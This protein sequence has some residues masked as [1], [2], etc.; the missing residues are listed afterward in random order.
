MEGSERVLTPQELKQ[1][2]IQLFRD[3]AAWRKPERIPF[4]A[5]IVTWKIINA[6]Y[7]FSEALH[8]YDIMQ[9]CVTKF[10]DTYRVDVLTDTGVRNPMRIP[11]AIGES[12]YYVD[13]EQEVLGVHAYSLCDSK[14]LLE[15]SENTDKFIWEK[16]LPRKFPGF[17]ELKLED[18]QRALDEQIA[19]NNYTFK[20]TQIVREKYGVPALTSMKCGFPNAGVEEMF[21]MVRGIKGLSI[22]MRRNPEALLACVNAYNAVSMEPVIEKVL[23]SEEGPDP[24]ACFD[25]G[26]ML[27]AHTVMSEAQ[28][29]KY[30]WPSLKRLLDAAAAK[31]KS[32]RITVE[33]SL[34]RFFPYFASYPKGVLTLDLDQDDIFEARKALPN[35]CLAGGMTATMLGR[36]T[37]KECIDYIK[38]LFDEMDAKNGGYIFTTD[39]F[40][41]YRNDAKPE[42][43]KAVCDF[44]S[45]FRF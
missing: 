18:F 9:E 15:L 37:A 45:D 28:W 11:E 26:I 38:F 22:D 7:K 17:K 39:K 19:F 2:R 27:L 12:S 25:L 42:N 20:V 36:G 6:G 5:N 44:I 21:S 16:M 8:N 32:V 24:D 30:Y 13:D 40:I 23:A 33:G 14:E 1:N 31:K 35:C 10:L 41:S 34:A 4:L 43:L 29:E 3:C